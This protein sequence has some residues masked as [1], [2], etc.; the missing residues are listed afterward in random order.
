[1]RS[2][3]RSILKSGILRGL[4]VSS[5]LVAIHLSKRDSCRDKADDT[6]KKPKMYEGNYNDQR[7]ITT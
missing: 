2:S 7:N 1:M 4:R 3:R 5:K 6:V